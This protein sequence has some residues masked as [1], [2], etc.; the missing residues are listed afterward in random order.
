MRLA[1]VRLAGFKSFADPTEFRFDHPITGIVGPNGC[2]KS[3]VVDAIKW[4]LGERS[5]KSLRGDAMLDV[6]FAGSAARKPIGVASVTLTFDNPVIEND[7]GQ[8]GGRLL[9]IDT[10]QVDVARRLH[11]DG[12]SE[13]LLNGNKCRLRDIKELFMDTGIGAHAYSIIEQGRVD[14]MLTANP[15]ERRNI[16]EEAAG[17][18]KFR[19]RKVEAA[20]KLERSEVNLVRV[21]E[22]LASTER[23]LRTIRSQAAKARRFHDLDTRHH[24]LRVDLALDQYHEFRERL[25]GLTSR[26]TSLDEERRQLAETLTRLE[27]EK[28]SA[29]LDR[30]DAQQR[31]RQTEERR[32]EL[33]ASRK[34]A[35]QRRDLMQR[36][37]A[38]SQEHID[39]N[40]NRLSELTE[41]IE[42]LLDQVRLAQQAADETEHQLETADETLRRAGEERAESQQVLV[43]AEN[44]AAQSREA[45]T[46]TQQA[47]SQHEARRDSIETRTAEL[48]E[49]SARL[50]E[51]GSQLETERST[52]QDTRTEAESTHT[53]AQARVTELQEALEAQDRRA[54]AL[55]ERHAALSGRL[56]DARHEKAGVESRLHLLQEMQQAREGLGDGAKAV[57]D[58]PDRF[59]GV[60]GL[61]ADAVTTHRQHAAQL[62][63][64]LGG[65]LDALLVDR[66]DDVRRLEAAVR[67]LQSR[68]AFVAIE[69]HATPIPLPADLPE[70]GEPGAAWV[71]PMLSLIQVDQ[72]SRA[73]FERLLGRTAV[74]WDL[75]AALMLTTGPMPGWRFVTRNGD[76]V[77]PDGRVII[78]HGESEQD[79]GWIVRRIELEEL[80]AT[81]QELDQQIDSVGGELHALTQTSEAAEQEQTQ[82]SEQL[83]EARHDA[84]ESQYRTQRLTNDIE[85]IQ[86]EIA[87][88]DIER[89]EVDERRAE[90]QTEYGQ[91]RERLER[92]IEDEARHQQATEV[93]QTRV[94][95]MQNKCN[96][97]QEQLTAARVAVGQTGEK[98]ESARRECRHHGNS[99]D[100]LTRQRDLCQEQLNRSLSQ[101]EQYEATV[102]DAEREMVEATDRLGELTGHTADLETAIQAAESRVEETGERLSGARQTGTRLE[103]DYHAVEISRREVEI[104]RES[105]EERCLSEFELDINAAYPPHR[106]HR[107]EDGFEPIDR[108]ACQSEA[109]TLREEIRQLGNVNLDAITEE[110]KLEER[111]EDLV[112]QVE[113]IDEAVGQLTTLIEDLDKTSR[114]RFAETFEAIR[115]HFAGP[116]GM[117]RK[118][119][120]GGNADMV[121]LPDENGQTDLLESG[122]EIRAKPPGKEPRVISQLSGGEKSMTAVALLMAI[123]KSKPSPFCILDEVDAALDDANVERF[124]SI[125]RP[126]LDRS[127]FIVITHHKLT[128]QSCD[129]LYGVTMQ[130]RG[131]SKRVAVR[132]ENAQ[133]P[134]ATVESVLADAEKAEKLQKKDA[135]P[136][137]GT[138]AGKRSTLP[139]VET[140]PS[141]ELRQQLEQAFVAETT[142]S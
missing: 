51:R 84:I 129:Q 53:T 91:L 25:D 19:A 73:M 57:L 105:L 74:V 93:A 96:Q 103:R 94:D 4:V 98:L 56:A 97:L 8:A 106:A 43:E 133:A 37:L 15:V 116:D 72:A 80:R 79:D 26:I 42:A 30:H 95:E 33:V 32:L 21:R 11:R 113:D 135:A 131:V 141:A 86:R 130:E 115:L 13:Y 104:K 123:F 49:Q 39:E 78:G 126:F 40:R 14:A 68:V 99:A 17:I 83:N 69:G 76:I 87:A 63:A 134:D 120:G 24:Q 75:E 12:R 35:Q 45:A 46:R 112:K 119:F 41:R 100:E 58:N 20:R 137:N 102:A 140:R 61:L 36:N 81:L 109:D 82:L 2:G 28:Q 132:V 9:D 18:A 31:Q 3:N 1:R 108:T 110:T 27:D 88:L 127:H 65:N 124:C 85:R 5:A 118:L 107:E 55:G 23:R 38:E 136:K 52:T 7:N 77:E 50:A 89:N 121:L 64:A 59:P 71:R 6:I 47:R 139:I 128:M 60:R 10:E 142:S 54:A 111:N 138:T 44:A 67:P 101:S 29:E 114:E 125:L 62:E 92:L 16:L 22:Q 34:H 48:D 122:V 117:F 66:I 70:P 90:L